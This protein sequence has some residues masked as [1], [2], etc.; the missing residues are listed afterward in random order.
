MNIWFYCKKRK[1]KYVQLKNEIDLRILLFLNNNNESIQYIYI[2]RSLCDFFYTISTWYS[3]RKKNR[4]K[5]FL[6]SFFF[7]FCTLYKVLAY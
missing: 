2:H 7:V 3:E 1:K 5:N 6:I 4:L